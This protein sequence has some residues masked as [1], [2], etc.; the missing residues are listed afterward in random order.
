MIAVTSVDGTL[1]G[2]LDERFGRAQKIMV[3]DPA[4]K[5]SRVIDN[6]LNMSASQGAGIQTAKNIIDAGAKIVISGHVGPNA[7]NVLKAAGIEMYTASN[8]SV[9]EALKAFED[10]KLIN[11]TG[12]DVGGHW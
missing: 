3:Y 2:K 9:R 6:K 10:G 1:D 7:F 8:M 5:D 11:L 12:A 4:T